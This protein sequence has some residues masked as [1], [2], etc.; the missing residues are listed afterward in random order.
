MDRLEG[1]E[2]YVPQDAEVKRVPLRS[3]P[4]SVLRK[5]GPSA[6]LTASTECVGIYPA[7]FQRKGQRQVTQSQ[8]RAREHM[9]T[10]L[11]SAKGS[12]HWKMSFVT[13]NTTAYKVL[14][15]TLPAGSHTQSLSTTMIPQGQL[16]NTE[17][18]AIIIH[19]GCI[20][21]SLKRKGHKRSA[22]QKLSIPQKP[23]D[24][25]QM[26]PVIKKRLK[27]RL[28]ADP[29]TT[30]MVPPQLGDTGRRGSCHSLMASPRVSPSPG[31]NAGAGSRQGSS[32]W[33]GG[34]HDADGASS[35]TSPDSIHSHEDLQ[36]HDYCN[37][38][39]HPNQATQGPEHSLEATQEPRDQSPS[40]VPYTPQRA[41]H[42]PLLDWGPS[43]PSI[44][45]QEF[46]FQE[47]A[48]R[49]RI[50]RME[51]MLQE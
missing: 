25:R 37:G 50:A 8:D 48:C 11:G 20:Y 10:A 40:Q 27:K 28:D 49:E 35:R 13:A 38:E 51:A 14:N 1:M 24:H 33:V 19:H 9:L 3:L 5:M 31:N 44:L 7:L 39:G 17:Q 41:S 29:D 32:Q 45:Q 18:D 42:S 36:G 15:E 30:E 16:S 22:S 43:E 12:N 46:D 6:E 47:L 4:S 34:R 26:E 21:L 2:I 23:A